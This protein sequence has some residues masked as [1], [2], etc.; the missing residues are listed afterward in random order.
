[1]SNLVTSN[2]GP[3][4]H[5]A[6]RLLKVAR[7]LS[8]F[9]ELD[10]RQKKIYSLWIMG[11]LRYTEKSDLGTPDP[12]HINRFL[13][14]LTEK[15]EI[16][17]TMRR[18]AAE[19]LVF[20]HECVLEQ[21]VSEVHGRLSVLSRE[22]RQRI[23]SRLSGPEKLLARIVFHTELDLSEALRLRVGDIDLRRGQITVSDAQGRSDRFVG[24]SSELTLALERHLKRVEEMHKQDLK[25]GHGTVDMPASIQKQFPGAGSAW[26]W[27]Y[28]F[29]SP[30]RTVDLHSGTERRYPMQPKNLMDAIEMLTEPRTRH[31]LSEVSRMSDEKAAPYPDA[32]FDP[33]KTPG[34]V[35]PVDPPTEDD[36]PSETDGRTSDATAESAPPDEVSADD[37][38]ADDSGTPSGEGIP[39]ADELPLDRS[40]LST[41][42]STLDE[43]NLTEE[44]ITED[45]ASDV[46]PTASPT[47][48]PTPEASASEDTHADV[49]ESNEPQPEASQPEASRS[50][51]ASDVVAEPSSEDDPE[52]HGEW[53]SVFG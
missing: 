35:P 42:R 30:R 1:M 14:R 7:M 28:A 19:A 23:L 43:K 37:E 38:S 21:S 17:N 41:L 24:L 6:G 40:V 44:N 12:S 16:D 32:Q 31:F 13:D 22:E 49:S 2:S 33:S 8:D 4:A 39:G 26:V 9:P 50:E 10:K 51:D 36:L 47:E 53:R 25:E 52:G 11:Y 48:E 3:P 18:Q 34:T 27:Q 45:G 15:D 20:F 5:E 29:P 46:T